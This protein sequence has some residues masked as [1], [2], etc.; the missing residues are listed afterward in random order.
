MNMGMVTVLNLKVVKGA[1][2]ETLS[3]VISSETKPT[4]K[5]LSVTTKDIYS[6]SDFELEQ[7]QKNIYDHHSIS[8]DT[9]EPKGQLGQD[10][11]REGSRST[12]NTSQKLIEEILYPSY[13]SHRHSPWFFRLE[14]TIG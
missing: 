1:H 8:D 5:T 13:Y 7:T 9:I 6:H 10:E 14:A 2:R 11:E 12:G 3:P 4:F